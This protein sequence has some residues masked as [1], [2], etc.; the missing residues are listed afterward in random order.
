M[1]TTYELY[2]V[3]YAEFS[4]PAAEN[5]AFAADVHDGPMP[6]DFFT[7]VAKSPERTFIITPAST[8]RPPNDGR[9]R[10]CAIRAKAMPCWTS[11]PAGSRT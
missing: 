6:L 3:K 9:A 7:W 8:S 11:T 2:A 4:R 1:S 5:F 10:S